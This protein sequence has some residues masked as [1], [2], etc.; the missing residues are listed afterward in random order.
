MIRSGKVAR[1]GS[2]SMFSSRAALQ[3]ACRHPRGGSSSPQSKGGAPLGGIVRDVSASS[4]DGYAWLDYVNQQGQWNWYFCGPAAV[5]EIAWT[6]PGPSNVDQGTAGAYMG[7][8][9][10]YGTGIGPMTDGLNTFV[11]VPD[12]GWNWF[13]FVWMDYIP[14]SSQRSDFVWHL[15]LDIYFQSPLA[16]DAWEVPYGPHL[17]NHPLDQEIFHW[18]Q[19]AGW[20]DYDRSLYYTDSATTVWGGVQP[21]NWMD[22]YTVETILGGRGYDW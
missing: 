16:G 22:M 19:I 18:F 15:H 8:N 21:Y 14:T 11:G 13:S 7:T 1:G 20:G 9:P 17:N 2:V 5:S 4:G 10:T 6:V 3:A 12:F